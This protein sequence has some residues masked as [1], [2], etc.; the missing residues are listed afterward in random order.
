MRSPIVRSV[1][2]PK[3]WFDRLEVFERVAMVGV[4]A[5]QLASLLIILFVSGYL[6][7]MTLWFATS[8]LQTVCLDILRLSR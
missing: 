2:G 5:I 1:A 7:L 8:S 4:R 6:Q 3:I